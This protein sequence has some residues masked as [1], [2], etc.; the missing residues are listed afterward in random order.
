MDLISPTRKEAMQNA[1]VLCSSVSAV[2]VW[3]GESLLIL[4]R[5][6][7]QLL[8]RQAHTFGIESRQNVAKVS[9]RDR[10]DYFLSGALL[11]RRGDLQSQIG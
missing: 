2:D 5:S 3:Q 1:G 6:D 10:K 8:D 7:D 9:S 11:C 4:I